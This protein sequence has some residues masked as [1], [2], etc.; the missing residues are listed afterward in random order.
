MK[1]IILFAAVAAALSGA[2]HAQSWQT[3]Q[4][5]MYESG[6]AGTPPIAATPPFGY[7][8]AYPA[9]SPYT[10]PP[11]PPVYQPPQ[12]VYQMPSPTRL[13][14]APAAGNC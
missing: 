10:G 13:P 1:R 9:Y 3:Q 7:S 5:N 4:H 12:P 6:P 2:A 8:G 11:S 14:C